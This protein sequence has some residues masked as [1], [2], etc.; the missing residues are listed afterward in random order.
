MSPFLED[1][2]WPHLK[3]DT[4]ESTRQ[5]ENQVAHFMNE[6]VDYRCGDWMARLTKAVLSS[7]LQLQSVTASDI[8]RL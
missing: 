8:R 7:E 3:T 4:L 5:T 6:Q 2:E 1:A